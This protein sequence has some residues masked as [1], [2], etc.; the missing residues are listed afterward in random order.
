MSKKKKKLELDNANELAKNTEKLIINRLRNLNLICK[1][2]SFLN[3]TFKI[4]SKMIDRVQKNQ[5]GYF[6]D[7]GIHFNVQTDITERFRKNLNTYVR[8]YRKN[9]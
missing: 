6:K 4:Q 7:G 2:I 5:F 9:P 3:H 1:N 8:G